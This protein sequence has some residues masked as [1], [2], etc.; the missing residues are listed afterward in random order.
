ML[1]ELASTLELQFH[2]TLTEEPTIGFRLQVEKSQ[3]MCSEFGAR[4]VPQSLIGR[5]KF[6][7][8]FPVD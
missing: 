4:P 2:D 3:S 7:I 5:L 1:T 6:I 8:E